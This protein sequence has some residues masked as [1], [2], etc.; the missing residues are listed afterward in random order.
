M[1][2]II[3]RSFKFLA[4]NVN[5]VKHFYFML[6]DELEFHYNLSIQLSLKQFLS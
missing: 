4:D 1:E 3:H 6:K 5:L 2:V